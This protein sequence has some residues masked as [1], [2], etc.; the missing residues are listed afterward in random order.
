MPLAARRVFRLSASI[1]LSLAVAYGLGLTMPFIAPL[2]AFMLGAKPGPPMA[3]RALLGAVMVLALMLSVGL[4]LIPM[5][6]HYPATGLMLALMGLFFANYVS[7]N[8]GKGAVG[9]FLT[10]GVAMISAIGLLGYAVATALIGAL[11]VG[12]VTAVVC[13]WVIYPIFPED[14][15]EPAPEVPTE[16]MQSSWL[17]LRATMIVFPSY[18]LALT[19]PA[20]YMPII[21]KAVALGQQASETEAK[22]AGVEL[23]GSTAFAG[24]LAI[25]MWFGLKL[26]PNL[27][28]FS[29]WALLFSIVIVG[30]LYGVLRSRFS[31]SFWQNVLITLFILIGPAVEDSANGKDPYKAF[32]VRLSLFI[33]VTLYAWLALV[34]LEWLRSRQERRR[35]NALLQEV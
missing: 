17:A 24:I 13:Q 27:W 26:Y 8:L 5:L 9:A 3:P 25:V 2:F 16:P 29:L 12:V 34:F 4:L 32:V 19:N 18:L 1:A 7:L 28:M 22:H 33:G 31:P 11:L 30:K 14:S 21:M 23:L 20:L 6:I 15:I 35:N 10:V